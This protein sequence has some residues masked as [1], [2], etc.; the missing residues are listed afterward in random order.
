[1]RACGG[2]VPVTAMT[3]RKIEIGALNFSSNFRVITLQAIPNM[4]K[5]KELK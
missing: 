4:I 1:M 2:G 5:M 3:P